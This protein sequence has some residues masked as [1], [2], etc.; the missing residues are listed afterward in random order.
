MHRATSRIPVAELT[1]QVPIWEYLTLVILQYIYS[2]RQIYL[3]CAPFRHLT[4][5]SGFAI[6]IE[7][8]TINTKI[9][10]FQNNHDFSNLVLTCLKFQC[11]LHVF[12]QRLIKAHSFIVR[13]LER[14]LISRTVQPTD[15]H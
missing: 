6:I 4:L 11:A 15:R 8:K 9:T 12:F 2:I 7:K 1:E 14:K 3:Q 5:Q 10:T 13:K